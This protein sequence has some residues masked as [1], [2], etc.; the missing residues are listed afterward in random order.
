MH[1]FSPP[2]RRY[3]DCIAGLRNGCA[4]AKKKQAGPMPCLRDSIPFAGKPST[5]DLPASGWLKRLSAYSSQD[6]DRTFGIS[7]PRPRSFDADKFNVIKVVS[8]VTILDVQ[9]TKSRKSC[10]DVRLISPFCTRPRVF[11]RL[12]PDMTCMLRFCN[13][14][15]ADQRSEN[16]KARTIFAI[17]HC[18]SCI[19][20]PDSVSLGRPNEVRR[21]F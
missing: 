16:S 10:V 6:S 13:L 7:V 9:C 4:G 11:P 21:V 5:F 3:W 2:F 17:A 20:S 8:V 18:R 12:Q 1:P 14:T 15:P 19:F